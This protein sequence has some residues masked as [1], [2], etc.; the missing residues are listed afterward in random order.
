[1]AKSK[2]IWSNRAKKRLYGIL[3]F[4][5]E[6]NKS[7]TSS[8]NLYRLLHR[9]VKI[10]I[11]FPETGLKTTKDEIRGLIIDDYIIYYEITRDKIVI[12][13]IC[14]TRQYPDSKIIK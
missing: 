10:L 3:D 14:D 4:H 5:I 8:I 2:I 6:R 9:E 13:T 7:K 12:H 1:M 11:K